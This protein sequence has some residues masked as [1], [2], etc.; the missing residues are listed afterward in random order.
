MELLVRV[1]HALVPALDARLV[2]PLGTNASLAARPRVG[3]GHRPV[4]RIRNVRDPGRVR[5]GVVVL[6]RGH[7]VGAQRRVIEVVQV[8]PM[9]GRH[10]RGAGEDVGVVH[11]VKGI[12][13]SWR[14]QRVRGKGSCW[15]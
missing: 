12:R 3:D 14:G 8:H 5:V 4:H 11:R 15:R 10:R 13:V 9:F 6:V 7:P 1:H 2:H